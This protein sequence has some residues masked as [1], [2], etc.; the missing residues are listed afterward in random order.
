VLA[1]REGLLTVVAVLTSLYPAA[2][3]FLALF[4]LRERL[5][6]VQWAGVACAIVGVTLIAL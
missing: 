3:V 5:G 1:A 6:P 4:I 2:T